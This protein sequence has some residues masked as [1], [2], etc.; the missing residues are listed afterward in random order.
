MA[1]EPTTAIARRRRPRGRYSKTQDGAAPMS[2]T[3]FN[4]R[5]LVTLGLAVITGAT[6]ALM[7][8]VFS[9]AKPTWLLIVV[10]VIILGVSPIL[11]GWLSKEFLSAFLFPVCIL[12]SL[13]VA[14]FING[15]LSY[16]SDPMGFVLLLT[17]IYGGIA[18]IAFSVSWTIRQSVRR[19]RGERTK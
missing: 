15:P 16:D 11:G 7:F 6:L 12:V 19:R 2:A 17:L 14:S 9:E 13:S 10:A 5:F 4:G 3:L 18:Y 8:T 1:A